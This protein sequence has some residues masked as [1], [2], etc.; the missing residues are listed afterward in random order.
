MA[1]TSGGKR[2]RSSTPGEDT[3]SEVPPPKKQVSTVF[4]VILITPC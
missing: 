4:F 3:E 2:A 1:S